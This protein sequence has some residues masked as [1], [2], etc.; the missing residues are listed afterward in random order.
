MD[1]IEQ[2][3]DKKSALPS[4]CVSAESNWD[5]GRAL[6]L[7]CAE[8]KTEFLLNSERLRL[9]V[10]GSG[11]PLKGTLSSQNQAKRK[12]DSKRPLQLPHPTW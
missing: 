11:N 6:A 1:W 2:S 9:P 5:V 12:A 10:N 8:E 7:G 4:Q 3:G